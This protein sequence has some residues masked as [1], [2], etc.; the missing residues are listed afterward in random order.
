MR[1]A[2][3]RLWM[4]LFA[5]LIGQ[6]NTLSAQTDKPVT[7]VVYSYIKVAPGKHAEYIKLEKAWKKIHAAKKKAGKMDG[8]G[9]MAV[10]SPSGASAE[11]NYIAR[12][13]YLGT[14]Q[15]AGHFSENFMPENW[16]SLLTE[17]EIALIN[18][19][20]EIR[21]LIKDEVW[22]QVDGVFADKLS[23][24]IVSVC[25]YFK[26]PEGKTQ[27]DHNK[28]EA[29]IWKPVHA[30][31]IKDGQMEGWALMQKEMPFGS[32]EPYELAAIDIY[33]DMKSYFTPWFEAYFKKIHPTKKV[34]DLMKQTIAVT[35]LV[36]AD[37][38]V[39]IDKLD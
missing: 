33:K 8:W 28:M 23:D 16:K 7:Y 11:Y 39:R 12:N 19:T 1:N 30:A 29:D 38:R 10:L 13:A 20:D 21:T 26:V 25:N 37:I 34:E 32:S 17:D 4:L 27:A 35:D 22:S 6:T 9:L 24:N 14:D 36:K 5:I 3:N 31:R 2:L 18:R 15:I